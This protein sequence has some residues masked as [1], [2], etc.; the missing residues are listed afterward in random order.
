[1]FPWYLFY[2]Y[3]FNLPKD[4]CLKKA[5]DRKFIFSVKV[6]NLSYPLMQIYYFFQKQQRFGKVDSELKKKGTP[7]GGPSFFFTPNIF[8]HTSNPGWL[9]IKTAVRRLC[10]ALPSQ[11]RYSH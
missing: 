3:F 2:S 1:M 5:E 7:H 9:N 6:A 11:E 10:P 8:I 4:T